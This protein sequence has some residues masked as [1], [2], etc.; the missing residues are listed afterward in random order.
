M[1]LHATEE[2]HGII[3]H[4]KDKIL[5]KLLNKVHDKYEK[6]LEDRL[7]NGWKRDSTE[8]I[9]EHLEEITSGLDE[10]KSLKK[11]IDI[12]MVIYDSDNAYA[13]FLHHFVNRCNEGELELE[14][15]KMYMGYERGS[16]E[17][18]E[19]EW[20]QQQKMD[21]EELENLRKRS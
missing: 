20:K 3:Q 15:G 12:F 7:E 18:W 9:R 13:D 11:F 2:E 10:D 8:E 6:I 14:P 17:W 1:P 5:K 16:E 19:Y 21:P 4:F